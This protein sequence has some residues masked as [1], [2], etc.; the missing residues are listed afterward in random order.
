MNARCAVAGMAVVLA[1][2]VAGCV[3]AVAGSPTPNAT[4]PTTASETSGGAAP[5]ERL[6]PPVENPKDLRGIDPCDLLTP[7][8]K[9]ELGLTRPVTRDTSPWGEDT[10]DLGG[11]VVGIGFSPDTTLGEGL[12]QAYRSKN[13][14]DNF[15]PSEV[16]GYPA[17][18][19]DFTTQSCGLFVGVSDEQTL[20]MELTRVSPDAPGKG[21]PCGFA[22]SIM[23]DVLENLPGA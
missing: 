8:Q 21:D 9:T 17:V 5:S 11:S 22:E 7:D 12:D 20:H 2:L 14:F 18:R 15:E 3:S 1:A 23:S 19:V 6:S 16:D 10:C 13:T 4:Q